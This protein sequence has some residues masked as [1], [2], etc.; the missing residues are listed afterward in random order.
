MEND[1]SKFFDSLASHWDEG[2]KAPPLDLL[3]SSGIKKGDRVLDVACG[4]GIITSTLAKLCGRDVLGID[5]SPKMIE[6][7][8]ANHKGEEGVQFL[9][10][11]FAEFNG[12]G[13]Y[14]LVVIYN[15]FPHFVDLRALKKSLL[16][17]LKKGGKAAILHSLSR[18]ELG[19]HHD[20]LGPSISRTIASPI[21]EAR[22]FSPEFSVLMAE[23]S[24]H[25][26]RLVLKK[27]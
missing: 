27:N 7:A 4:T 21:E 22:F 12:E 20:G 26:Y 10:I 24:D 3:L 13:D 23:E 18:K 17:T 14:D 5:I 8:K 19:H 15:A 9:C 2:I 6:A 1:V 16:N 11:D 25:D